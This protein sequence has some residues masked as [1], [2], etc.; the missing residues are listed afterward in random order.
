MFE[1]E[2]SMT[3]TPHAPT[4]AAQ[5]GPPLLAPTLAFAGL[6]AAALVLGANGPRPTTPPAEL[7]GYLSA[8]A[9]AAIVQAAAVYAASIPLAVLSAVAYRRLRR[10]GVTAPGSAIALAGG[11]LASAMLALSGLAAWVTVQS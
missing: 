9:G 4:R 11:L 3:A 10:I 1:E 7:A 2:D 6:A 8:H 5:A